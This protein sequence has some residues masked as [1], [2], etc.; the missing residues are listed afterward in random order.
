MELSDL[1]KYVCEQNRRLPEVGLVILTEGNVSQITPDRKFVVIKPSGVQYMDLSPKDMVVVDMKGEVVEGKLQPSVDTSTHIEI[2]KRYS[3]IG[4]IT[5]THSQ[6]ATVFAQTEKPIPCYGTTH[7]DAFYGDIPVTRALSDE[8]IK[9]GLEKNTVKTIC[10]ILDK[11]NTRCVLV[12]S[13]GP[14]V[15]GRDARE[16]VDYASIV[17]KVATMAAFGKYEA[18]IR[19]ALFHQ[20]YHRKHGENK[21]YGQK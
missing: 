5:H 6:F 11:Q 2:Y 9:D 18:P 10:E 8:E 20:H 3:E 16:S 17:E 1:K 12:A 7:A 13:H 15:F 19:E 21:Y 4:G 14:F